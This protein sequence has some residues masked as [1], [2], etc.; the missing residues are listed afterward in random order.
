MLRF[1]E[2]ANY[3]KGWSYEFVNDAELE[4][5]LRE[6][7]RLLK[8]DFKDHPELLPFFIDDNISNLQEY[9]EILSKSNN[10]AIKR[11]HDKIFYSVLDWKRNGRRGAKITRIFENFIKGITYFENEKE[12]VDQV[13][14]YHR[15]FSC[16]PRDI[17][18][19]RCNQGLTRKERALVKKKVEKCFI[20]RLIYDNIYKSQSLHFPSSVFYKE[21]SQND[22]HIYRLSRVK[23]D[24]TTCFPQ[25]KIQI[26]MEYDQMY[27]IKLTILREQRGHVIKEEYMRTLNKMDVCTMYT[28]TDIQCTKIVKNQRFFKF[29]SFKGQ[30]KWLR[31]PQLVYSHR[32]IEIEH[33][34]STP[35]PRRKGFLGLTS[36]YADAPFDF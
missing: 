4:S 26:H 33:D 27:P 19:L 31:Q 20:E 24:F 25:V 6:L 18:Q 9:K 23:D 34:E 35:P 7:L 10:V 5:K 15:L 22:G 1:Y 2:F 8:E 30:V 14:I 32:K 12:D 13:P 29:Q 28:E 16:G 11:L 21:P 36:D 3:I 17:G